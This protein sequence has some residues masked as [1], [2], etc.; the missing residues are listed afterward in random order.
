[1]VKRSHTEEAG[2]LEFQERGQPDYWDFAYFSFTIGMTS[3]TSDV[4]VT[5]RQMRRLTLIHGILSFFFNTA[6]LAMAINIVA[7]VL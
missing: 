5:S 2:G 3:Q 6:V 4:A 1:M 7:S